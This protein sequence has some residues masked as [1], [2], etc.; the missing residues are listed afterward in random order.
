VL[1]RV[2]IGMGTTQSLLDSCLFYK[3]IDDDLYLI[4]IYVDDILLFGPPGKTLQLMVDYIKAAF[5]ITDN[6]AVTEFLGIRINYQRGVSMEL[7]QT[8]YVEKIARTYEIHWDIHG[9][10]DITTPLPV[11]ADKVAFQTWSEDKGSEARAW[12]EQFP[13]RQMMG[14]LIWVSINTRPD[15]TFGVSYCSQFCN[16]PS[17][18]ACWLLAHLFAYVVATK[19]RGIKFARPLQLDPHGMTDASWANDVVRRLSYCGGDVYLCGGP[20][21]FYTKK[22]AQVATSSMHAEYMAL[23]HVVTHMV[24]IKNLAKEIGLRFNRR[25]ILFTD[26][27]A[28]RAAALNPAFHARIKHVETLYHTLRQ[29]CDDDDDNESAFIT[30]LRCPSL[31]MIVDIQTKLAVKALFTKFAL[32]LCGYTKLSSRQTTEQFET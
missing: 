27:D 23:Y 12:E 19:D 8:E 14:A 15:I 7:D 30:V 31:Y 5:E 26:A 24:F 6:G 18:G 2:I 4:L 20:V 25:M 3:W 32:Q 11:D 1:S 13:Y 22:L 28:A 29:Y 21:V 10:K 16:N 17:F 9:N